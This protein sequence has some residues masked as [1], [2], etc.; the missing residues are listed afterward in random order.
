MIKEIAYVVRPHTRGVVVATSWGLAND[1]FA[2]LTQPLVLKYLFDEGIIAKRFTFFVVAAVLAVTAFTLWRM[3]ELLQ[4]LYRERANNAIFRGLGQRALESYHRIPYAEVIKKGE[5]YFVSRMYDEV[6]AA[7]R[8]VIETL[9][10]L[11]SG[12]GAFVVSTTIVFLLAPR[13]ALVL[14]VVTP[15]LHYLS[16]RFHARIATQS[17]E[18]QEQEALLR[19][20]VT[21]IVRSYKTTRAFDLGG[22]VRRA[23]ARSLERTIGA[24]YSR[25]RTS[26]VYMQVGGVFGSWMEMAVMVG[27]GYEMLA[28]RMTFG[29]FMAFTNAFWIATQSI[30]SVVQAVPELARLRASIERVMEFEALGAQA[31]T[32]RLGRATDGALRL[33]GARFSY[34]TAPVLRDVGLE[35]PAGER[36]LVVGPNGSGKSTLANI[37]AGLLEP[38][39]GS[40]VVPAE[41]SAVVDPVFFAPGA[42]GDLIPDGSGAEA[43]ALVERFELAEHLHKDFEELSAGQ[44]K[45]FAVLMALLKE[46]D[47]YVLDE[48]LAN[49]DVESRRVVMDTILERTAGRT[50]VVIMHGDEEFHL[51]FRRRVHL[52]AGGIQPAAERP[53]GGALSSDHDVMKNRLSWTWPEP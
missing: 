5:G 40:G 1:V 49:V 6:R 19:T 39:E 50:L 35:V 16:A 42:V 22:P 18:E 17:K 7:S 26:R 41:V 28:G 13:L 21:R 2:S 27:G 52:V 8:P 29:G 23:F 34:A 11:V 20:V 9:G 33:E 43:H 15:A 10:R 53:D 30:N 51:L 36:L 45:K 3:S 47:C 12:T 37:M 14:A 4:V 24:G 25:F 46:A 31:V 32:P 38:E 48:P 44:R